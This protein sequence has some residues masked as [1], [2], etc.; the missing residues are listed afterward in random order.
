MNLSTRFLSRSK[1]HLYSWW[2]ERC[3]S[4]Q[5]KFQSGIIIYFCF[6]ISSILREKIV[7]LAQQQHYTEQWYVIRHW[8]KNG[9]AKSVWCFLK[10]SITL[11]KE[12]TFDLLFVASLPTPVCYHFNN[13]LPHLAIHLISNS[14][15]WFF[16]SWKF[17][18]WCT[19]LY[20]TT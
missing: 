12:N 9:L 20:C 1:C 7:A 4:W 10:L 5:K 3:F 14:Q 19:S 15:V 17:S 8:C 13:S 16:V 6:L 18:F 2:F 11:T